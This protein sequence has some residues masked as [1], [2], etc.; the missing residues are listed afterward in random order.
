M[1][2]DGIMYV[3]A[4]NAAYAL[5]ATSGRQLWVYQGPITPGLLGEAAAEPTAAL[6]WRATGCSCWTDDAHLLALNKK[7]GLL[8]W[9][10]VMSDWPKSQYSAEG[11][12]L[13]VG[14]LVIAG[15]GSRRRGGGQG[16]R[17]YTGLHGRA[18]VAVLDHS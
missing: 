18:G 3:T 6:R 4:V 15:G 2:V 1:V 14:D 7:A 9:D 12:A 16:I 5:D 10:T 17:W 11:R 8:L 13:P